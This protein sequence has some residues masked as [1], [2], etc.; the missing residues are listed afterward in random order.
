MTALRAW[1]CGRDEGDAAV[2]AALVLPVVLTVVIGLCQ[3]GL[4]L[5]SVTVVTA[6]VWDGARAAASVDGTVQDGVNSAQ[7]VLRAG[8]GQSAGDFT[9]PAVD[10]GDQIAIQAQGKYRLTL[11]W[12][13]NLDIPVA[14]TAVLS[15]ER[16][17]V[18]RAG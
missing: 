6:A 15:K 11:P 12:V 2:E 1:F 17:R 4:Y 9:L 14:R 5:H 18:G 10:G 7:D 8:L 13:A 16:F 3:F